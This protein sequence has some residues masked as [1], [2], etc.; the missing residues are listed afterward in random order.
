[1]DCHPAAVTREA[2]GASSVAVLD[3]GHDIEPPLVGLFE[4]APRDSVGTVASQEAHYRRW[5]NPPGP[6]Q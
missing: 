6:A 4:A 2:E 3:C 1:M 5:L